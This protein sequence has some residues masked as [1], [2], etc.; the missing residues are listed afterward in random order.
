MISNLST[1][2]TFEGSVLL[3]TGG[4]ADTATLGFY[5]TKLTMDISSAAELGGVTDYGYPAALGMLTTA[6]TIPTVL[7]GKYV[8]EKMVETVEY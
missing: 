4:D 6:I 3:Y 2:F 5:L 7:F 8:L 1:V